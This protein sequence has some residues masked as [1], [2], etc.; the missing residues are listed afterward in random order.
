MVAI[1]SENNFEEGYNNTLKLLEKH[2]DIDGLFAITDLVAVGA[3]R[4][5]EN[6]GLRIPKDVAVIGFSN[7]MISSLI[8]PQLSTVEQNG[9]LIGR[10]VIRLFLKIKES[11]VVARFPS[12]IQET[13]PAKLIIRASSRR[14]EI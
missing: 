10:K 13:V 4:T 8:T 7:W 3:L 2:P 14:K 12:S 9:V 11:D 1:C 6:R 5:F